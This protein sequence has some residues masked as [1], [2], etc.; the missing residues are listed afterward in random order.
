MFAR[1]LVVSLSLIAV[2]ALAA[3]ASAATRYASPTGIG[4]ASGGCPQVA[5]CNFID[6]VDSAQLVDGDEV[7]VLPGDHMLGATQLQI[8]KH[9][10]IHGQGPAW[11]TT[12]HSSSSTGIGIGHA[13]SSVS[14]LTFE[15]TGGD[16]SRLSITG[17]TV[18]R[19]IVKSGSLVGSIT[20]FNGTLRDSLVIN[21]K[22]TGNAVSTN[23]SGSG[24]SYSTE[25]RG[26][27]LIATGASASGLVARLAG[28]TSG[29][30]TYTVSDSIIRGGQQDIYG[31]ATDELT[32]TVSLAN[33]NFEVVKTDLP[34]NGGNP[35]TGIVTV[36][37]PAN[38][39]NQ[40]AAPVFL[41]AASGNFHQA[42]TS[43][44]IDAGTAGPLAFRGDIDADA[45]VIDGIADIGADEYEPVNAVT[46]SI[47][48]PTAG[49]TTTP[50]T[51]LA[52]TGRAG[53]PVRVLDGTAEIATAT[54]DALGMWTTTLAQPLAE[55]AHS[56]SV[57]TI[58]ASHVE[59]AKSATV[60][61][62]VDAIPDPAPVPN[63]GGNPAPVVDT[64]APQTRILKKPNSKTRSRRAKFKFGSNEKR[65]R[66][67]C[68]LDK[69]KYR[70][71]KASYSK[72][73]KRGKHTLRVRAVDAAGNVDKTPARVRW[74]VV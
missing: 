59:S 21:T 13:A 30:L 2:L 53:L 6:A 52:G 67:E 47:T 37:N 51:A 9:V 60:L 50:P 62:T 40:T 57:S 70:R 14:D 19:S 11:L 16:S 63:T 38:A 41:D 31:S 74:R 43:P 8:N 49:V 36:T 61:V 3:P 4:A 65:V 15:F 28:G 29:S 10:D 44:T 64:T 42:A 35:G 20:F 23:T 17:G 66:F 72:K 22:I 27:T 24:G 45:R 32:V 1:L 7:V 58:S 56:L 39:G 54:A 55:G 68:K 73:V 34:L 46:G 25:I 18:E 5:P 71:C 26:S 33:S 12:I 69:G 48:A